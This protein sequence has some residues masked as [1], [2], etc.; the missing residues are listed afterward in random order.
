[1]LLGIA[2]VPSFGVTSAQEVE[3]RKASSS[4]KGVSLV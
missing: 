2:A 3:I 4:I 1:V